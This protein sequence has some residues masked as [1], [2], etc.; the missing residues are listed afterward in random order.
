MAMIICAQDKTQQ[1]LRISQ[2]D[3]KL[4]FDWYKVA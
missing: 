3:M 1:I 2:T 4:E